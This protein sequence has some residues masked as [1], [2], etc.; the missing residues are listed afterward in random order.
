MLCDF[1]LLGMYSNDSTEAWITVGHKT[2]RY[3]PIFHHSFPKIVILPQKYSNIL[4]GEL[5]I[6]DEEMMR[7]EKK[8]TRLWVMIILASGL[9]LERIPD[10]KK[11]NK[12]NTD[13]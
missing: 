13:D 5:I 4:C 10:K 6:F 1:S 11:V 3:S 12:K 8:A 2:L 9:P 7:N